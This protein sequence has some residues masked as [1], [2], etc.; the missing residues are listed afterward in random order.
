MLGREN[1]NQSIC[2][3]TSIIK[4]FTAVINSE[5]QQAG[6]FAIVSH[7]HPSLILLITNWLLTGQK[8]SRL[9]SSSNLR[10]FILGQSLYIQ[11]SII[12]V[13]KVRA[14][15]SEA[16]IGCS[17][18]LLTKLDQAVMACQGETLKLI[19]NTDKLTLGPRPN[20]T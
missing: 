13:S 5:P 3:G 1:K 2:S 7:F 18:E 11:P 14:Y 10:K 6:V 19:T 12:V 16:P 8:V 17:K 20:A 15:P 9:N 4:V